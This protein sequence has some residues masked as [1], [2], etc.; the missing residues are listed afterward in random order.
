M[1]RSRLLDP[2]RPLRPTLVP[3]FYGWVVLGVGAIGILASIPGQTMG[4]SVFSDHL[5]EATGLSRVRLANAYLIGTLASGLLLPFGG[6]L[7]DR[8]GERVTAIVSS[9]ALGVALLG[10]SQ[11]DRAARAVAGVAGVGAGAIAFVY[12]ACGFSLLRFSGQ[13]MLTLASRNMV[14]KWFER[15]RGLA[16]GLL[17]VIVS[18][19]FS[20][21]PLVLAAWIRSAGGWREAWI[22]LAAACGL[23]MSLVAWLF[24]RDDPEQCGLRMDGRPANGGS[25]ADPSGGEASDPRNYDL[26]FALRTGAFW[27]VTLTLSIHSAFITGIT[28]HIVDLGAAAGLDQDAAVGLFP[29]IAV[30]GVTVGFLS[31][32]AADRF[33]LRTIVAAMLVFEAIGYFAITG[34]AEPLPRAV[35]ILG[36]GGTS[37]CFGTLTTV[38]AAKL[39]GRTHLGSVSS[40]QMSSLVMSSALGPSLLAISRD[41]LDSYGPALVVGGVLP[42]LVLALAFLARDPAPRGDVW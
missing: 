12:L 4:V 17:S 31:G 13:G 19:G 42:L 25:A 1:T 8:F 15:R 28:F 6:R 16:S 22:E 2:N 10:L 36:L 34:L 5:I 30:V 29:P 11:V 9:I 27:A 18:L 24:Y 40:A 33:R 38:A 20:I 7:L 23:G 26:A 37:G 41:T 21:A 3:V 35:A 14:P 39:F 32:A